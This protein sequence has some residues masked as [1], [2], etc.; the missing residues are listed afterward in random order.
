ME[1]TIFRHWVLGGGQNITGF[2]KM[3]TVFSDLL[4]RYGSKFLLSM[5]AIVGYMTKLEKKN[6]LAGID[7]DKMLC[8]IQKEKQNSC[9]INC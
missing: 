5:V 8:W 7:Q 6:P 9:R 1:V 2:Y 3:S 4:P